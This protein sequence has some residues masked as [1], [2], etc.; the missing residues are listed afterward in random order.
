MGWILAPLLATSLLFGSK[1]FSAPQ[2]LELRDGRWQNTTTQPS[3]ATRPAA[4]N[5]V[6]T[7]PELDRIESLIAKKEYRAAVK[8]CIAWFKANKHS[9]AMD[10]ALFLMAQALYGKGDRIRAFYY[11]DELMDEH[12]ESPLFYKALGLQFQI[13]DAYLSGYKRRFLGLPLLDAEDEAVEMLYRIQ[14]RSP[15]SELAEKSLLR[16]A[17]YFYEDQQYDIAAEVYA[18]Y[19]K[20]YPR[21][22]LIPRVKLRQ[23][24]SNLA[25]FRGVRFDPT[26][27][28]D[29]RTELADI[30]A[31]YPQMAQQERVPEYVRRIDEAL[32]RKLYVTADFYQRT[33]EPEASAYLYTALLRLYPNA[34]ESATAREK[35]KSLPKPRYEPGPATM[36]LSAAR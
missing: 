3:A 25:Q 21:S 8:Q 15:G 30:E 22:P 32:A 7:T 26:P 16:T 14:Q 20:S 4:A 35:L 6:I 36:P 19:I 34:P 2:T 13:A 5:G 23:A 24:F 17:D 27:A 11:L 18:A 9:P 12:P 31:Q 10:R 1:V 29:A 28:L 33:H